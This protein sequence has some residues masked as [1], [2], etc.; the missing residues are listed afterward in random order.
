MFIWVIF[1]GSLT[2]TLTYFPASRGA[3]TDLGK[4]TADTLQSFMAKVTRVR[5]MRDEV[6]KLRELVSNKY[7][8]D[9]GE[10]LTGCTTQW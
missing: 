5:E 4:E 7:A 8:E 6:E 9:L 2:L 10:N 3:E 1:D